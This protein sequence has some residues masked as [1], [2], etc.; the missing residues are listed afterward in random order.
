[1]PRGSIIPDNSSGES[2]STGSSPGRSGSGLP[3]RRKWAR[4]GTESS[5]VGLVNVL[6][7]DNHAPIGWATGS[8]PPKS[9]TTWQA[10]GISIIVVSIRWSIMSQAAE[11]QR[12]PGWVTR[13]ESALRGVAA[14]PGTQSGPAHRTNGVPRCPASA[15][16]RL[17]GAPPGA[18][19]EASWSQPHYG[20]AA[21][22]R[23]GGIS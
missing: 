5:P 4:T 16:T 12:L 3:H 9:K 21:R 6:S 1:M 23:S 19:D 14:L 22:W 15:F 8:S 2:S 20:R 7:C 18:C 17:H 11:V 13:P 10:E